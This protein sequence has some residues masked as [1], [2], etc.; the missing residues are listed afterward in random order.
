MFLGTI[1]NK[2][3][4]YN[5]VFTTLIWG[6]SQRETARLV[7]FSSDWTYLGNYGGVYVPPAFIRNG[8]VYWSYSSELGNKIDLNGQY[9]PKRV[10]L[11][12]EMYEFDTSKE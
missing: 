4:S 7:I 12:G 10:V 5:L 6:E 9:P 11:D 3:T 2:Y 1:S 8:V